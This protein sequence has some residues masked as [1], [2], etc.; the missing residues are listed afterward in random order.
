MYGQKRPAELKGK[1]S[2]K[3]SGLE[4]M[5]GLVQKDKPLLSRMDC[6]EKNTVMRIDKLEDHIFK[7]KRPRKSNESLTDRLDNLGGA[8]GVNPTSPVL[9]Q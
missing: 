2:D 8:I 1:L 9:F 7:F 6:I 4:E 5:L 3:L